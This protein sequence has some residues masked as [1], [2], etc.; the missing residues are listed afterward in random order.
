MSLYI[1]RLD[2]NVTDHKDELV[3]IFSASDIESLFW[4]VDECVSPTECEYA[5]LP[6]GGIFWPGR[7]LT[8]KALAKHY[9]D[10]EDS[11]RMHW[12]LQCGFDI[13][14]TEGVDEAFDGLKF[15]PF[16]SWRDTNANR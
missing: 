2:D 10:N 6:D 1:V 14:F 9:E 3:G 4:L 5:K 11:S 15:K 16:P 13:S 7:A 12:L 8:I